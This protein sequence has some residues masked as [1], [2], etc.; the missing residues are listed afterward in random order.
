MVSFTGY[1]DPVVRLSNPM[2]PRQMC[3][4]RSADMVSRGKQEP[5]AGR[6]DE[7][8]IWFMGQLVDFHE[9]EEIGMERFG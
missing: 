1:A 5:E 6:I 8:D 7:A 4:I 9:D 3:A 2:A